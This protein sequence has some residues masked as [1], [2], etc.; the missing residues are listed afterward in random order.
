MN[1][2]GRVLAPIAFGV[3]FVGLWELV[4]RVFDVQQFLLPR[5]SSIAES[6]LDNWAD[7]IWPAAR[8]TGT[9]AV[10]GLIIGTLLGIVAAAAC[11]HFRVVNDSV[12]PLAAAVNAMPIIAVAP[13]FNIWFG[14][15]DPW[16][17]R[18]VVIL[19]VFFPVFVN[20]SRGLTQ[21]DPTHL[22]LMRSY[23]ASRTEVLVR[24]RIPNAV[25]FLMSALRVA[26]SLAVIA[27]IVAEYFGGTQGSLGQVITQSAGLSRYDRAWAAVVAASAI[28]LIL[29]G[30]ALALERAISYQA[31]G[32]NP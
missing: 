7:V 20:V 24:V 15:T 5:P 3:V 1:R 25:P 21:V 9:N 2:A 8:I 23:A 17:R 31:R 29:F 6:F 19:V 10:L 30:A 16:S 4:V 32:G 22:E 26:A 11:S 13:V 14:S 12:T 18:L 27:A 28:G